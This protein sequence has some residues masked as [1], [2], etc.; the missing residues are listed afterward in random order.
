MQWPCAP[1]TEILRGESMYSQNIT[2]TSPPPVGESQPAATLD[3]LAALATEKPKPVLMVPVQQL[4]A[5]SVTG[6]PEIA[7]AQVLQST[8]STSQLAATRLQLIECKPVD[9][10]DFQLGSSAPIVFQTVAERPSCV[11]SVTEYTCVYCGVRKTSTSAGVDGRVRIRCECGGKRRDNKPRMHAMW[12]PCRPLE[13]PIE[14]P[15]AKRLCASLDKE[16]GNSKAY[17]RVLVQV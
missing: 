11:V 5:S 4:H 15:S 6:L 12:H 13:Q 17:P 9:G 8:A 3:M 2:Q 7:T 1:L 10:S 16:S 14:Q